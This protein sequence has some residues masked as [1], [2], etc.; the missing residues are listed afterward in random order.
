MENSQ[1][2]F[3]DT[4]GSILKCAL[5]GR[6][7]ILHGPGGVGKSYSLRYIAKD[8]TERNIKVFIT[9]LTGVAALNLA[10]D[11]KVIGIPVSTL[12]SFAG[13]GTAQLDAES[14]IARVKTKR[15]AVKRWMKCQV[16]IIDE[17]S[18]LGG[19]LFNKLD[20]IAKA[21]RKNSKPFGGMQLI[22]SGDMLQLPPV[23]DTWVFNTEEWELL[24]LRPFI[25]EVPY[26][27]NNLDFFHM[28]L[29]IRIGEQTEED[30]KV[31]RGRVR[32]NKKMQEILSSLST[33]KAGE[34][35]RPT[36]FF[37]KRID[38]DTF[39]AIELEKLSGEKVEF[40]A[41]DRFEIKKGFPNREEYIKMLDDSIP[42][43]V[44]FKVGAQV[45]L[46]KNI[47]VT[48]GLVNG[49]RGVV[50]EIIKDE[51]LIVKF[52]S[53][54]KLRVELDTSEVEDKYAIAKRTQIPFILA[55]GTTIH[56]CVSGDTMI[57]TNKGI[58]YIKDLVTKEGWNKQ[59][60]IL[61][62][63]GG[64]ET[65]NMG[66]KGVLEKS[67]V[68][69]T[70]MGYKLEGSCRHPVLIRT[71]NGETVWKKLPEIQIGDHIVLRKK[72]EFPVDYVKT[73]YS[74]NAPF[75]E[76]NEEFAYFLGITVGDGSYRDKKNG[77][78]EF[79]NNDI[80]MLRNFTE[81]AENL[82][83]VRVGE[84]K[85]PKKSMRKYFCRKKVRSFLLES[86][87][88]YVKG[89]VKS[90]PWVILQSPESVVRSFLQGLYDSD[91]GVNATTIHFTSYSPKL[92]T[93]VQFMLLSMGIISRNVS[94]PNAKAGAWRIELTGADARLFRSMIGFRMESKKEK[95]FKQFNSNYAVP[96]S[97]VGFFPDSVRIATEMQKQ[98]KL[99]SRPSR[100][101]TSI[102][103]GRSRLNTHH[104]GYMIENIENFGEQEIG[105]ELMEIYKLGIFTDS[106][107][108][109]DFGECVM[110]D[111]E[112]PG[113]H[114]FISN[115]IVSHNSQSSTLDY[116]VIDLGPSI[117]SEGQ[118]Y[119]ALSRCSS[120]EGLFVSEFLP[121]SIMVNK[122]ALRYT[123]TLREK[124]E[125]ENNDITDIT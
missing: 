121:K 20:K 11:G 16:L 49:S 88:D 80:E 2:Y 110:Y 108:S 124:C 64:I 39:N 120:I 21:I 78:V 3:D 106:V 54:I 59:E 9:A 5:S 10:G 83:G 24:N 104:I 57:F 123:K 33:E 6:N 93:E 29:R 107:A 43:S 113:S 42:R 50:S 91:G 13:V 71:E 41:F 32:A 103:K 105:R 77:T 25:L 40:I 46:K 100:L 7:I 22:F 79:T 4:L 101:V 35:I 116:A 58:Q 82:L 96:K 81:T 12:H 67:I 118:A 38:V 62:T 44:C 94:M 95:M 19:S 63:V 51:A 36:M 112:V 66:F 111:V 56:K 73:D 30:N 97:N 76:V 125:M 68:I 23:K 84:Y 52:L 109:I 115:G 27:Y 74:E 34:I 90:T 87:L 72:F 14:L 61:Q 55:W 48:G 122:E 114:S 85:H 53:G 17:V 70:R 99:T 26:R 98:Y 18:M 8:L 69:R 45:M 37:S 1:S 102:K 28:L 89:P 60:I 92:A 86:G 31:I 15:K 65:T 47:D 75:P 119:V 117:F